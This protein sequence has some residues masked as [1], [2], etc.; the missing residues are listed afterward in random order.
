MDQLDTWAVQGRVATAIRSVRESAAQ[1]AVDSA[2]LTEA[3]AEA[4]RL[5][6]SNPALPDARNGW[7]FQPVGTSVEWLL[8]SR[9]VQTFGG[10]PET[11]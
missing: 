8:P 6:I 11:A 7:S 1:L 9:A 10:N 5:G 2:E 3:V 4:E